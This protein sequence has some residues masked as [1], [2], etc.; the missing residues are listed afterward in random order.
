MISKLGCA[1][2]VLQIV[3]DRFAARGIKLV[4]VL[5]CGVTRQGQ[6]GAGGRR[7]LRNNAAQN[8]QHLRTRN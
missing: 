3:K 7:R 1:F 4:D 6:S 8:R 5:H 2:H